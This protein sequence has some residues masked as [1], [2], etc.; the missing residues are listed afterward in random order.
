LLRGLRLHY[1]LIGTNAWLAE[2]FSAIAR[3][4]PTSRYSRTKYPLRAHFV[5][6]REVMN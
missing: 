6:E 2:V 4:R 3:L 5:A 1:M